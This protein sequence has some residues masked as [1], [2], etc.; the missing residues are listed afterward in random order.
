[1]LTLAIA[2]ASATV[3]VAAT[4]TARL[5]WVCRLLKVRRMTV[6]THVRRR[7]FDEL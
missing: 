3:S 4:V 6:Q 2:K 1:M 7:R 5:E